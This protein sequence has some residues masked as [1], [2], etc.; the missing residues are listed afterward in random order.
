MSVQVNQ[1]KCSGCGAC[2]DVCPTS[3]ISLE[4]SKAVINQALC[5]QCEACISMCPSGALYT[6]VVELQ[7]VPAARQPVPARAIAS[8]L[9]ER[10]TLAPWVGTTLAFLG[11]EIL[12]RL[13]NV[14]MAA[15]EQRLS[16]Q[17]TKITTISTWPTAGHGAASSGRTVR[18]QRRRRSR[19][20]QTR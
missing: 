17:P 18:L 16:S 10:R 12:P 2:L 15:L 11:Q 19:N 3:A 13:A 1:E 8:T 6:E 7:I 4:I 20:G 5:T 9:P 14:A